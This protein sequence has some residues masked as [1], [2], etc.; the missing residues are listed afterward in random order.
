MTLNKNISI[1]V[2]F[3]LF[4]TCINAFTEVKILTPSF[5]FFC[6]TLLILN[7]FIIK[8]ILIDQDKRLDEYNKLHTKLLEEMVL[9]AKEISEAEKTNK[10][11]ISLN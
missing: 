1:L 8:S 10:Q 4:I 2:L 11:H 7:I 5:L 9:F 3:S 6:I